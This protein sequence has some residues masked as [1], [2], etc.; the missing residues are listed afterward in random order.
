MSSYDEDLRATCLISPCCSFICKM[1]MIAVT[2]DRVILRI[3]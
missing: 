3:K 1:G 2:I